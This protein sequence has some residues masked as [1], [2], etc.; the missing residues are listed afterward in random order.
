[1]LALTP[2]VTL[3]THLVTV[4]LG[5][6]LV[7]LNYHLASMKC[8]KTLCGRGSAPEHAEETCSAPPDSLA[9]GEGLAAPCLGCKNPTPLSAF[10]A[11]HV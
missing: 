2:S 10:Q 7:L 6:V 1:M 5:L 4:D 11:S 3:F 9:G 8:K